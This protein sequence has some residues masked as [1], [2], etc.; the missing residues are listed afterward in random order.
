MT[1]LI[2]RHSKVA[3]AV[4]TI[5]AGARTTL[6]AGCCAQNWIAIVTIGTPK[7]MISW[8]TQVNRCASVTVVD[9][10]FKCGQSFK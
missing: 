9:V 1:V 4:G 10:E 8:V 3:S 5:W 6:T 2:T 7:E